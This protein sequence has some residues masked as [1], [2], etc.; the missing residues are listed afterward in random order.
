MSILALMVCIILI[1]VLTTRYKLHPFLAL[2]ASSLLYGILVGMPLDQIVVSVNDGFGATLG[3]IGLIIIFG[4]VIGVFLEK[5]GAAY[6]LASAILNMIG[7]QRVTT[8]MATIGY[9]ISIPVFADSGFLLVSPL[10][11]VLTKKAGLSLAATA[12]ALGLGLT[13]THTMVPP[14][15]GPAA[16]AGILGADVGLVILL[17]MC[18]SAIALIPCLLYATKYAGR[19]FIDPDPQTSDEEVESLVRTAPPVFRSALPVALPIFFIVLRS[20]LPLIGV[21]IGPV[22]SSLISFLGEPVI[23][24]AIG[25]VFSFTLPAV[26]SR[27]MLSTDGWVGRSLTDIA[28]VLLITGAGGMFGKVLQNSGI[29]DSMN[30]TMSGLQVG[31]LFPFLLAAA[32]KTAQGSSTVAMITTASIVAPMMGELGLVTE[33]QKAFAVVSIGAGSAVVSHAN[34]SFFWVVTQLSGMSVRTGYRLYT[35]GTLVLGVSSALV[36]LICTYVIA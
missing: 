13:A 29:A 31:I 14:T 9:F 3:R 19:T 8:A 20:T 5:S 34:D 17:G 16:A 11:K 6:T 27:D 12:V 18:V 10:N 33:V 28:T 7:K 36:L 32:I 26:F 30:G 25:A 2:F 4:V 24:L 23:A 35:T 15:P 1:V 22:F 21:H